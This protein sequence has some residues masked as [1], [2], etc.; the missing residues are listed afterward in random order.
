MVAKSFKDP[1]AGG[2]NY[3]PLTAA[4]RWDG[5][6]GQIENGIFLG[7]V[8]ALTFSGPYT[9]KNKILSFDFDT[10]SLKL[11]PKV[12]KFNLNSKGGS[13]IKE[14]FDAYKE[15][16]GTS[17]SVECLSPDFESLNSNSIEYCKHL[18][19]YHNRRVR[20]QA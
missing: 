14:A 6:K 16:G 20:I 8:A 5:A 15:T 11:G 12:F 7:H 10:L 4:Q 13:K 1:N 9:M 3:F 19:V 18:H 2:G 17:Y